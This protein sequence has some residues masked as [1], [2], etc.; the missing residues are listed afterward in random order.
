MFE[1]PQLAPDAPLGLGRMMAG[2]GEK[3]R[4]RAHDY[5][6][7]PVEVTRAFLRVE[8]AAMA[9]HGHKVWECCG[10]GGAIARELFDHG[11]VVLASDIVPD[12]DNGVL[13]LNVLEADRP[14]A[15]MVVTNPP[16]AIAEQIIVHMWQRLEVDYLALLLK[17]T[18]FHAEER[19]GLYRAA[20]P[21]RI[22]AL[23]WRPD[24]TGGGNSTMECSWFVWD[25]NATRFGQY[26]LL[27]REAGN[28]EPML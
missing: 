15:G 14:Y 26:G 11:F 5:Y 17:A 9:A 19:R 23:T 4:R 27:P 24:F 10:R 13:G 25:R 22:H 16:F 8:A 6:P 7:T 20:T 28:G 21:A 1:E 3:V 2:G 12:P 18:Y